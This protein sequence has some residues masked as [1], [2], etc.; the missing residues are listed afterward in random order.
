MTFKINFGGLILLVCSIQKCGGV[1]S[2]IRILCALQRGERCAAAPACSAGGLPFQVTFLRCCGDKAAV[3]SRLACHNEI[4]CSQHNYTS[5]LVSW[6]DKNS[7]HPLAGLWTQR[8][9][10]KIRDDSYELCLFAIGKKPS[11][12]KYKQHQKRN[13]I[14][15]RSLANNTV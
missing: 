8:G 1:K 12:W 13:Q 4:N 6:K 15:K 2:E 5:M 7:Q 3:S 9:W 10:H 14:L 11:G